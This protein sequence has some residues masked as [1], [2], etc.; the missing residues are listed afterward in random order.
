M[1]LSLVIPVR[2][3]PEGLIRLLIEAQGFGWVTEIIVA[4]DASDPPCGPGMAGLPPPVAEDPRLVWLRSDVHRG[5]GRARNLGL[6]RATGAHLLFFDS[7]DHFL[8][9]ILD[10]MAALAGPMARQDFDFCL[11]RHLDS[12]ARQGEDPMAADR[13]FWQACGATEAPALLDPGLAPV[14]VRIAAYPWNKIYRTAFLRDHRIHCTEIM[15]H[16]DIELHWQSFLQAGRILVSTL[17]GCEHV[18]EGSGQ[19]LTNRRGAERLAVFS[20]LDA[21]QG[22]LR[23]QARGRAFLAPFADFSL[24][25][26]DWIDEMLAPPLQAQFATAVRAHLRTS[27]SRSDFALIALEDPALAARL[28]ARMAGDGR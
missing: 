4:D 14:L 28:L 26:C 8:P 3:D 22:H 6:A 12:R 15:V 23:R 10:L 20:A 18:V 9:G 7:D 24:R 25:L 5:A 19:R 21:V 16:N 11:F 13:Q 1:S 27:L 17:Q 2:N